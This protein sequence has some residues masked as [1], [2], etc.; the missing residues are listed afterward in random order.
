MFSKLQK[1]SLTRLFTVSYK[2]KVEI[3]YKKPAFEYEIIL[4]FFYKTK[5]IGRRNLIFPK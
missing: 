2:L 3:I 5:E 4:D 1:K